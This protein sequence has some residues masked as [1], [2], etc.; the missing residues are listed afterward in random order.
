[1]RRGRL[2]WIKTVGA[3]KE[4]QLFNQIHRLLVS[5]KVDSHTTDMDL[6]EET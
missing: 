4:I 3:L 2:R 6:L 5:I 1:L